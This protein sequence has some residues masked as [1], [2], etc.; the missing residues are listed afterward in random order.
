MIDADHDEGHEHYRPGFSEDINE[1]LDHR[2]LII[3][4]DRRLEVLNR[5]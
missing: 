5:E 1:D 3:T 2:L 4:S